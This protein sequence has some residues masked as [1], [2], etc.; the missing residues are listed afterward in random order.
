MCVCNESRA[1]GALCGPVCKNRPKKTSKKNGKKKSQKKRKPKE[2]DVTGDS[3]TTNESTSTDNFKEANDA[4]RAGSKAYHTQ[5]VLV[6]RRR[7]DRGEPV[8]P[9]EIMP[10]LVQITSN[11]NWNHIRS[12]V[13]CKIAALADRDPYPGPVSFQVGEHIKVTIEPKPPVPTVVP[14]YLHKQLSDKM[15]PIPVLITLLSDPH[16]AKTTVQAYKLSKETKTKPIVISPE[17]QNSNSKSATKINLTGTNKNRFQLIKPKG[18]E[19][20]LAT[21]SDAKNS[22]KQIKCHRLDK[23]DVEGD[24]DVYRGVWNPWW[25]KTIDPDKVQWPDHVEEPEKEPAA[26]KKTDNIKKIDKKKTTVDNSNKSQPTKIPVSSLQPLLSTG[27]IRLMVPVSMTGGTA[28]VIGPL[29]VATSG[30][31]VRPTGPKSLITAPPISAA[32][33]PSTSVKGPGYINCPVMLRPGVPMII[34]Q[35][36]TS[37]NNIQQRPLLS[38]AN[39]TTTGFTQ[40]MVGNKVLI[41][42]VSQRPIVSQNSQIVTGVTSMQTT[43]CAQWRQPY[44]KVGYNTVVPKPDVINIEPILDIPNKENENSDKSVTDSGVFKAE[45]NRR[46]STNSVHKLHDTEDIAME[47]VDQTPF[48][49]VEILSDSLDNDSFGASDTKEQN[50]VIKLDNTVDVQDEDESVFTNEDVFSS[51]INDNKR[52]NIKEE[53]RILNNAGE[54]NWS[55]VESDAKSVPDRNN[56]STKKVQQLQVNPEVASEEA[57]QNTL[58]VG[59]SNVADKDT[60]KCELHAVDA[61]F[62]NKSRIGNGE[63][64]GIDKSIGTVS[65]PLVE[66]NIENTSGKMTIDSN[67]MDFTDHYSDDD[68]DLVIDYRQPNDKQL[69][70]SYSENEAENPEEMCMAGQDACKNVNTT[71]RRDFPVH[72]HNS[73]LLDEILD[74]KQVTS[75]KSLTS[76]LLPSENS[77]EEVESI[78]SELQINK[79]SG[80]ICNCGV[81]DTC[82]GKSIKAPETVRDNVEVCLNEN[83]QK[84]ACRIDK[85]QIKLDKSKGI[86]QKDSDS[87]D[88]IVTSSVAHVDDMESNNGTNALSLISQNY[89]LNSTSDDSNEGVKSQA[90]TAQVE[91]EQKSDICKP[92]LLNK[93]C[94]S[95]DSNLDV[96]LSN[97]NNSGFEGATLTLNIKENETVKINMESIKQTIKESNQYLLGKAAMCL[98]SEN[99]DDQNEHEA[100]ENKN[101]EAVNEK[102]VPGDHSYIGTGLDIQEKEG[103]SCNASQE[104]DSCNVSDE[105][106]NLQGESNKVD[107]ED[108]DKPSNSADVIEDPI[109]GSVEEMDKELSSNMMEETPEEERGIDQSQEEYK[110]R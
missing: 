60:E 90:I 96:A 27:Q 29:M 64:I 108:N 48:E 17:Q 49:S 25:E 89:S 84:A 105:E 74:E 104:G 37:L 31:P 107:K 33:R 16:A 91:N 98:N 55:A 61:D 35:T 92:D 83:T 99:E 95:A 100:N 66:D 54:Q 13:L 5:M 71:G 45:N 30:A 79:V 67:N 50:A 36:L 12:V 47:S 81:C 1:A 82:R 56:I 76:K 34:P 42:P 51:H 65:E 20:D 10:H 75:T 52:L 28:K 73:S 38:T 21:V 44:Q 59:E 86:S 68:N 78:M 39:N 9:N 85:T 7:N 26:I 80:E 110:L 14:K 63:I 23:K 57:S 97:N 53:E 2:L 43:P 88:S 22:H 109:D 3:I 70:K 101:F 15:F 103:D 18:T 87:E 94:K 46:N 93:S 62:K 11:F 19:P 41:V 77:F 8:A 72:S 106:D 102:S 4:K 32:T 69:N 24:S 6:Q 40:Q 58:Q